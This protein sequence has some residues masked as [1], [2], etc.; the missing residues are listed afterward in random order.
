[1][2]MPSINISFMDVATASIERSERGIV[3]LILK[4]KAIPVT[5]PVNVYFNTDIPAGISAV[6]KEQIELSLLGY[7]KTPRMVIC[8]FISDTATD[9]KE[10]LEYLENINFDYLAAPTCETDNQVTTIATWIKSQRSSNDKKC[11]AVLPNSASDK[12]GIIN[13]TTEKVMVG[14]K[15]YTTEQYCSRITGLI[16]GTPLDISCT[17]APLPELT[18]C[19]HLSKMDMDKAVEA[20]KLLVFYDGEKVKVGR[21]VNSLVTTTGQVSDS[22]KKIKIVE[23]MDMIH[24]DIKKTVQDNYLGKFANNYNNKCILMSGISSYYDTLILEGL[25]ESAT[26]EIDIQAQRQYLKG[27]GVDTN[28]MN[29]DQVKIQNTRSQV[30]LKSSIS[31]LD[32]IEDITISINI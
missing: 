27:I 8:Y 4:E 31:I 23:I 32:A 11:K 20:G 9:Y 14:T 12:E 1:M 22:F 30:F 19:S 13:F 17:F 28:T 2:G 29:D 3:A 21:G 26:I 25:L 6:N 18:N 5:N 7:K 10:A 15:E 24:D 16:A